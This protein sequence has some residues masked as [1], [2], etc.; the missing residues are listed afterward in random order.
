LRWCLAGTGALILAPTLVCLTQ[1]WWGVLP[2]ALIELAL[3][4]WALRRN[5]ARALDYHLIAISEN[6]VTVTIH[7]RHHPDRTVEFARHWTRARLARSSQRPRECGVWIESQGHRCEVASFLRE[8]E[9]RTLARSLQS[10]I[11]A[12][13]ECPP[14]STLA[15]S[16]R[17]DPSG[18]LIH[19]A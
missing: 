15:S 12:M 16:T 8:A 17:A 11:G 3:F 14:L 19:G 9:R 1:R 5:A 7:E 18:D 13:G 6:T 10:M 4:A 2:F